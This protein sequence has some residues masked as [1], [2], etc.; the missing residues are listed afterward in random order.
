MAEESA[1][2]RTPKP[3]IEKAPLPRPLTIWDN[4]PEEEQR[5]IEL[6]MEWGWA[7]MEASLPPYD[8]GDDR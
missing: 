1:N 3:G 6:F 5:E 4:T 7:D 2:P 8:W